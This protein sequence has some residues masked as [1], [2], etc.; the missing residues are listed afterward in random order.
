MIAKL[1]LIY[2][3][4]PSHDEARQ[5]ARQAITDKEAAC[6][7][8]SSMGVS[9]FEWGGKHEESPECMVLFKTPVDRKARLGEWIRKHHPYK[10]PAFMLFPYAH[11]VLGPQ[12]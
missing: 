4:W 7:H 8:I 2:T 3:S 1:T 11:D 10:V 5:V 6:V 12:Y 9:V